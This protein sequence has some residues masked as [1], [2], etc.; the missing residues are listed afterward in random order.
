MTTPVPQDLPLAVAGHAERAMAAAS[1]VD[2]A[3]AATLFGAA[4]EA[5]AQ[6]GLPPAVR[7]AL[8]RAR[9]ASL[10]ALGRLD[11]AAADVAQAS[12]L[13]DP[14]LAP[15][16]RTEHADRLLESGYAADAR[17][18]L[19][20]EAGA[21]PLNRAEITLV[22][23]RL[24][25]HAGDDKQARQLAEAARQQAR[26]AVAPVPY[27]AASVLLA[28][29]YDAAGDRLGA[30]TILATA[31]ATLGDLL[32]GPVARTWIEPC[33]AAMRLR[34]GEVGFATTKAAHDARRRAA[35]AEAVP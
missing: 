26:E 31:W 20:S 2:H 21:E 32:G 19:P 17:R 9:S 8:L 4:L 30:Y 13:G 33:L 11:A 6:A 25:R 29:L 35:L 24:A 1:Q 3:A 16:L 5:A 18:A 23:A 34:W 28:D 7:I 15:F 14:A 27:F 12:E 22:R 10:I